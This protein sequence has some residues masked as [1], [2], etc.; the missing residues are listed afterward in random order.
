MYV[1]LVQRLDVERL[2]AGRTDDPAASTSLHASSY[3]EPAW[4]E[5]DQTAIVRRT[6]QW[7]CHVERLRAPGQYV[8]GEVAGMPVVVVRGADGGLR[9]FYNVCR[10]RA[11]ELVRGSGQAR[12]IVCPYHAWTYDLT[13]RLVGARHTRDLVDFDLIPK[14]PTRL[15][16]GAACVRTGQMRYFDS[17]D[18]P[19]DVR[20]V[21][22][23]GA[24]PPAFP[25]VRIG[26]ELYWDG[27]IL[28]NTPVEAVF[29]DNPRRD[30][31]VFAVHL[32]NPDGSEPDTLWQVLNRQ[33]DLQYS[34]RAISH[35]ERQRQLHK[36]R[37]IIKELAMLLPDD[38]RAT[39]IVKEMESYGC[40]THMHVVRLLAPSL[41]GEDHMKDIDFSH[42]GIRQRSEA[43]YADT[44][45]V[46]ERAPW[47]D[48]HDPLE[49]V[50]L[51][52]PE[53]T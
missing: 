25:A 32:W 26:G 46:L 28:S 8:A 19:L 5:L 43:G 39:A 15:T 1:P 33:K 38:T 20:H 14:G 6:W 52:G 35:V 13:G 16:V 45:R 3:I 11:H 27:G 51:H 22:A 47:Q 17:R 21:M 34:S 12:S 49:G 4:F 48:P 53:L 41:R 9:A 2:A 24:L 18:E 36:L 10:H 31:L 50:I 23:S 42:S 44:M 7:W 29:D 37:H 30:S 40:L